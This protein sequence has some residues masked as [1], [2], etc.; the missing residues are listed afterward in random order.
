[1]I[2]SLIIAGL[3]IIPTILVGGYEPRYPK[4]IAS[5]LFALAIALLGLKDG[6]PKSKNIFLLGCIAIM[7]VSTVFVMQ[8]NLIVGALNNG[9]FYPSNMDEAKN[10][11]NYKPILYAILF[12]LMFSTISVAKINRDLILKVIMWVG[13]INSCY[14]IIQWFGFDQFVIVKPHH[15]IG[16]VESA[17]VIGFIGQPTH[18]AIFLCICLPT[19]IYFKKWFMFPIYILGIIATQSAAGI[20]SMCIIFILSLWNHKKWF[21]LAIALVIVTIVLSFKLLPYHLISSNG[22]FSTWKFILSDLKDFRHIITGFGAGAYHFMSPA[23]HQ[24]R[25]LQAH[26]E[27][28]EFLYNCGI[29]GFLF[30]SASVIKTFKDGYIFLKDRSILVYAMM[31]VSSCLG[32]LLNFPWQLGATIFYT[33]VILGLYYNT[34]GERYALDQ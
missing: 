18:L 21:I 11:W 7:V 1:M 3:I 25:F 31:L 10:L 14:A 30:L 16:A 12:Y 9:N 15:M 26:N 34:I 2:Q 27:Y 19:I 5:I 22:R 6:I 8:N 29:V 32:A 24:N 23:V 17:N 28:L 4:E 20:T 33:V 13:F